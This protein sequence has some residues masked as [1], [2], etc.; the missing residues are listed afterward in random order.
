A[1][2]QRRCET[3]SIVDAHRI[4]VDPGVLQAGEDQIR[5]QRVIFEMDDPKRHALAILSLPV[6]LL[7]QHTR[8]HSGVGTEPGGGWLITAQKSPSSLSA[9]TKSSNP[10]GLTTNALTPSE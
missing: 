1:R 2:S 10:T 7:A 8:V 9:A 3:P 5:I 6:A 4:A